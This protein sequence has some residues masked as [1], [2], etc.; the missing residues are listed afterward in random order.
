MRLSDFI[1]ILVILISI[2]V[3]IHSLV[4]MFQSET[5]LKRPD[6]F[7]LVLNPDNVPLSRKIIPNNRNKS[8]SIVLFNQGNDKKNLITSFWDRTILLDAEPENITTNYKY[9]LIITSKKS[10]KDKYDHIYVPCWS[11][12]MSESDK[13]SIPDLLKRHQYNKTKFCAFMYSNCDKFSYNNINNRE[14]FFLLMNQRKRVDSLGKCNHNV[15]E[16]PTRH[17]G[18]W[19]DAAVETYKSYKFVIAFENTVGLDG[20]VTE[21]LVL[22][23]LA[24]CIPIYYGDNTTAKEHFNPDCFIS[25]SDFRNFEDCIDYVLKVDSDD[26]LY[27]KYTSSSIITKDNLLKYASWYYGSQSFYAKLYSVFSTLKRLPYVP[28]KATPNRMSSVNIKVVNLDRSVQRWQDVQRQFDKYPHLKYERFPAVDGR[29]YIDIYQKYITPRTWE[30]YRDLW[31]GEIGIYLSAMELCYALVHDDTNDYYMILEDDVIIKK[32]F[33]SVKQ[34]VDD[35][36]A[37]WD[38]IFVGFNNNHCKPVLKNMYTKMTSICMPGNFAYIIRKRAAQFMINFA[39]PI[40]R[41]IDEMYRL[42]SD[43]LNIYLRKDTLFTVNY[44]NLSTIDIN[45]YDLDN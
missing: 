28:I 14:K 18:N 33:D 2:G 34:I 8:M 40:E 36:P 11:I 17:T 1:R 21:K 27:K 24:G 22:P 45:R 44:D 13:Y 16:N 25:V 39:F 3:A 19:L 35:A 29:L 4:R 23:L 32:N 12:M 42:Y 20:Y 15:K 9:D 38:I 7:Q 5:K 30:N 41:P 6:Y 10:L 31:P 37:N 26:S 43:N